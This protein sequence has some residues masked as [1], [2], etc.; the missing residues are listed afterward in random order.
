MAGPV[1]LPGGLLFQAGKGGR[2]YLLS[3]AQLPRISNPGGG[4]NVSADVCNGGLALGGMA[5][6]G[7]VVYVPCSN[8][9]AA[10]Q[11]DSS[12]SFHVLWNSSSGSSAPIVAG[13]LV[14]SLTVGGGTDL[15][16]LDPATGQVASTLSLPEA[17]QHFATP[18][19]GG[20]RL[21]VGAGHR[22]A[23]FAPG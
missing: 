12:T 19:A 15:V 16:G 20:G 18:A 8:G 23:A 1:L 7:S 11:I 6:A 21:Y 3:Q 14:W 10:V 5:A 2:G 22:L 4:E 9:I 17:N 13:G